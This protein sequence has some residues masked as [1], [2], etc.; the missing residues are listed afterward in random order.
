MT[1]E[2]R[3]A[4]AS[5]TTGTQASTSTRQGPQRPSSSSEAPHARPW[6]TEGVPKGAPPKAPVPGWLRAAVWI[7]AYLIFFGLLTFQD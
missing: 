1:T 3:E 2:D 5:S 7:A 4:P 6:R